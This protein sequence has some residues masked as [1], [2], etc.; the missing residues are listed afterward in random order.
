MGYITYQLYEWKKLGHFWI[1]RWTVSRSIKKHNKK[2]RTVIH[3][4]KEMHLCTQSKPHKFQKLWEKQNIRKFHEKGILSGC[5]SAQ[6]CFELLIAIFTK[7][8]KKL[9]E[10]HLL[11]LPF[12]WGES[13]N[14]LLTHAWS[15]SSLVCPSKYPPMFS[16]Q[17]F[18]KSRSNKAGM[19][20]TMPRYR[21]SR[22][23][24]VNRETNSTLISTRFW[25]I[26]NL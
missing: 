10:N 19:V 2:N 16:N 5:V 12:K 3:L 25:N 1:W 26:M 9:N 24:K 11:S 23:S 8:I 4:H 15:D 7:L 6:S 17:H 18:L 20:P 13:H 14:S 22:I 21:N